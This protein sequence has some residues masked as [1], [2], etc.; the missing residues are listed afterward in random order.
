MGIF[1]IRAFQKSFVYRLFEQVGNFSCIILSS[2]SRQRRD[3]KPY[4]Q[5]CDYNR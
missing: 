2:T 1:A 4:I 5:N 3:E